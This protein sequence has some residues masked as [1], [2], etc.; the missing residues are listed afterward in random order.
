MLPLKGRYSSNAGSCVN[1]ENYL[2][3]K[4]IALTDMLLGRFIKL[5]QL[6]LQ[7]TSNLLLKI[8]SHLIDRNPLLFC[9]LSQYLRSELWAGFDECN[10]QVVDLIDFLKRT[11]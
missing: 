8:L 6:K 1:E 10:S 3:L 4:L 5:P 9:D 2:A 7:L 11:D